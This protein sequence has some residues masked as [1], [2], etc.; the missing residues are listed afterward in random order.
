MTLK[1]RIFKWLSDS[2][3]A[4]ELNEIRDKIVLDIQEFKTYVE[5][6]VRMVKS[7]VIDN[8]KRDVYNQVIADHIKKLIGHVASDEPAGWQYRYDSC[9]ADALKRHCRQIMWEAIDQYKK[10]STFSVDKVVN[11]EQFID[12]IVTRIKNKQL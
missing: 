6:D 12:D 2:Q 10:E 9:V 7:D 11:S 4:Q 1:Q 5:K 3:D 8:I